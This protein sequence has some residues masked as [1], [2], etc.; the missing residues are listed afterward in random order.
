MEPVAPKSEFGH[1]LVGN[2]DPRRVEIQVKVA[3]NGQACLGRSSGNEVD[4][5][6]MTDQ[7]LSPPVL[8]DEREQSVFD[9]VPLAGARREMADRDL[10]PGLVS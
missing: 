8:A 4:D 2:L 10:Q 5:D 7:R 6:L 3:F 1:L 9:L